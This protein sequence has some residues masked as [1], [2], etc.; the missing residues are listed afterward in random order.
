VILLLL[1]FASP[2]FAIDRLEPVPTEIEGLA[3]ADKLNAPIPLDLAFTDS[4]GSRVELARFFDG[5]RPVILTLN[6][7]N[8]PRLCSLQ[9]N[10]LFDGLG[11]LDYRLG[12]EFRMVCV[13]IDPEEPP[14][15]AEATRQKYLTLYDRPQAAEG[16]HFLVGDEA[17]IRRLAEAI[18]FAYKEIPNTKPKEYGHQPVT[19]FCTP[20]G[21]ISGIQSGIEFDPTTLRLALIEAGEGKVGS[22][23]EQAFMY[24]FSYDPESRKYT[25]AAVRVM[26]AGGVVTLLALGGVLVVFWRHEVKKS[27][28]RAASPQTDSP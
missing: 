2:V 5:K 25:L 17:S 8:C 11:K 6:Y 16:L 1:I 26:Q 9:L 4:D 15:R 7:S 13:S 10:G 24:C 3:Q 28:A 12:S 27:R 19:F 23:V 20:D 21:R 14:A 18:G 22:F